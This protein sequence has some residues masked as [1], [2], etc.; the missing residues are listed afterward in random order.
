M[1]KRY[2]PDGYVR[3]IMRTIRDEHDAIE[4]EE[5]IEG[6]EVLPRGKPSPSI[7]YGIL[8]HQTIRALN[9]VTIKNQSIYS[10]TQEGEP[11]HVWVSENDGSVWLVTQIGRGIWEITQEAEVELLE[12]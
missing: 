5:M 7:P 3:R 1:A 9:H 2:T 4:F 10:T 6:E 12:M 11:V 8:E